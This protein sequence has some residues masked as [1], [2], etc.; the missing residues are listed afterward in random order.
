MRKTSLLL[1]ALLAVGFEA[2]L[3]LV[4]LR[5]LKEQMEDD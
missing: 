3:M 4:I 2:F 1:A 5:R